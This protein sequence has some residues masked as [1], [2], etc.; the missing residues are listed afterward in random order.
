MDDPSKWVE[1]AEGWDANKHYEERKKNGFSYADWIN[2]ND[3]LNWVMINALEQF[4]TGHGHP[5]YGGV[6]TMEDWVKVLDEI[7]EGF[8]AQALIQ[9]DYN[10]KTYK[11]DRAKFERGMELLTKFYNSLWD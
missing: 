5:Y 11:E 9:S 3:Y 6:E 2:F 4:K 7:I 10:P 1:A 8:K